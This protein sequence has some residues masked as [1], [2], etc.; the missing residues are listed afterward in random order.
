MK[1]TLI[2]SAVTAAI[3][4]SGAVMADGNMPKF[5][6][7]IEIHAAYTSSDFATTNGLGA[8]NSDV[9]STLGLKHS[10]E[11]SPGVKAYAKVEFDYSVNAVTNNRSGNLSLDEVY[12]GVKGDFGNIWAG[13]DDSLYERVDII[14]FS[15]NLNNVGASGDMA[16][17]QEDATVK[18]TKDLS[19]MTIGLEAQTADVFGDLGVVYLGY[20]ADAVSVNFAYALSHKGAEDTIGVSASFAASD[21]IS[22]GVQYEMEKDTGSLAGVLATVGMD[23]TTFN[24]MARM[25]MEDGAGEDTITLA[26]NAVH[27][28]SEN[29]ELYVE[30]GGDE[31]DKSGSNQEYV[32]GATYS[33]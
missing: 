8:A 2:A 7:D 11:I 26:A 27:S 29:L 32:A 31:F 5:Y 4:S 9:D 17:V 23:A 10:H 30:V 16:G 13:D 18:Y 14:D 3:L 25:Y 1:K 24:V 12:F 15:N 33:F 19:G 21:N 28:L 20:E 6:G 22:V